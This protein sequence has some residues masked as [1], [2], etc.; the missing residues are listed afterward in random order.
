MWNGK[1]IAVIVP[2]YNESKYIVET[3]ETIPAWVDSIYAVNDV[4]TDNTFQLMKHAA[5]RD[6]RI[7]V[8]NH[9]VNTGVGGSII[10]GYKLALKNGAD[11]FCVMAGDGQMD[12][13]HL[14]ELV[15]SVSTNKCDM[16]KGNRFYSL[17]SLKGMPPTRLIGSLIL[18]FLT[19]MASGFYK[20][21]D[22]QNGYVAVSKDLIS[23]IPLDVVAPRYDFENDFLCWAGLFNARVLDI[24]IKAR[25]RQE[26]S[27]LNISNTAPKI[28]ST[29]FKG[30][31]R[32]IFRRFV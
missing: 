25:Y 27:T 30:L 18:T 23:K 16:A 22:P 17:K 32:R 20:I 2:A 29:L 24:P 6:S 26:T 12:P 13:T 11:I 7:F 15:D 3:L 1:H 21:W 31:R 10:S 28:L 19:R 14:H 4:S 9:E 8:I 5:S